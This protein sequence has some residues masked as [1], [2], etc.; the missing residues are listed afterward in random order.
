MQ[1][2]YYVTFKDRTITNNLKSPNG[3]Y[4]NMLWTPKIVIKKFDQKISI[5][6]A[7]IIDR[8][9]DEIVTIRRPNFIEQRPARAFK[10]M[11]NHLNFLLL[12]NMHIQLK[13][14]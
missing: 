2:I 13:I 8:V 12:I 10:E 6:G 3:S 4:S 9:R 7:R 1:N 14:H 5:K 11:Y